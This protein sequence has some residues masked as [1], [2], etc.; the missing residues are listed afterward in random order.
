ETALVGMGEMFYVNGARI[1]PQASQYP[2]FQALL[3]EFETRALGAVRFL[4]GITPDELNTFVQILGDARTAG[5]SEQIPEALVEAGVSHIVPVRTR[6]L[7][8]SQL[9]PADEQQP[10]ERSERAR[11]RQT[12]WRA[13]VGTR[14]ILLR[15]SQTGRPALRQAKRLVQPIVD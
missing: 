1:R 4:K 2:L 11:A 5:H 8:T 9:A 12:F 13:V 10:L 14:N 7:R 3:A 15:A 6:D